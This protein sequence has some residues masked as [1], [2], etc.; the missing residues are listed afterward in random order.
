MKSSN[1][2]R[3]LIVQALV[4]IF[5][6]NSIA[7]SAYVVRRPFKEKTRVAPPANKQFVPPSSQPVRQT[8]GTAGETYGTVPLSFEANLGQ[9]DAA[10]KFLAR[11]PGYNLFLTPTEAVLALTTAPARASGKKPYAD[12]PG[13]A[14]LS[15]KVSTSVLR[16]R[17]AGANLSPQLEGINQLP[18]KVNYLRGRDQSRWNARVPTYAGVEYKNVYSGI[19]A[20]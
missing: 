18:G 17:F 4:T 12:K 15:R 5:L 14:A 19:D 6:T 1:I 9:V 20:V 16:M 8:T 10:V 2:A 7:F 13:V 3:R 11:G